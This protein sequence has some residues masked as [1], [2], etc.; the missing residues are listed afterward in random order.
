M[1]RHAAIVIDRA[2]TVNAVPHSVVACQAVP[3]AGPVC[4]IGA[5]IVVLHRRHGPGEEA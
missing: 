5:P 3:E 4:W 1:H 2:A